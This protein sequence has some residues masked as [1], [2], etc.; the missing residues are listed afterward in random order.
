[1][2]GSYDTPRTE[3]GRKRLLILA[4]AAFAVVTPAWVTASSRPL[5]THRVVLS[6]SWSP[7]ILQRI[8][9]RIDPHSGISVAVLRDRGPYGNTGSWFVWSD[10][11]G[12]SR[13]DALRHEWTTDVVSRLYQ[14]G[15]KPSEPKL[16]GIMKRSDWARGD[17]SGNYWPRISRTYLQTTPAALRTHVRLR[18]AALG[19]K[20]RSFRVPRLEGIL[21]PV[22]VLRVSDLAKFK[23]RYDPGCAEG[24]M[25]GPRADTNGSPYF[26]FFLSVTDSSGHRIY[27]M[28]AT[29]NSG[30]SA[31]SA[32][33]GKLFPPPS[34]HGQVG[35]LA[36]CP[37]RFAH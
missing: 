27:S 8:T 31:G 13:E 34:V 10:P 19:L 24:W 12:R 20:I 16:R 26:G 28:A 1:M 9:D 33:E 37:A 17:R 15:R 3:R 25:F 2:N 4:I 14:A 30:G 32:L 29:P 35:G 36:G 18:A 7:A 23:R 21:A 6:R 11:R 22:V 5:P